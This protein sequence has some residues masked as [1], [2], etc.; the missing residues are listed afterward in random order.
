VIISV[1][2]LKK[3]THI[4][5]SIDELAELI[6]SRLVEIEEVIDLGKKYEGIIVAKVKRVKP[7]DNADKLSVVHIDDGG[8]TP[9]VNRMEDGLVEVV[10]GAPNVREG[11]L[12]AWMPPGITV[13]ST[14]DLAEPLVLA[15]RELRGVI[16]NGMLGSAKELA[17][18]E[19]HTGIVDIDLD[20]QPGTPFA[21]AF[22]LDD[23]LLDIENKSLTHRPD[24]FGIIGFAREAAAIQGKKFTS[25]EWYKS[26]EPKLYDKKEA[27]GIKEPSVSIEDPALCP[28]YEA[29][30]IAGVDSKLPS[31]AVIQSYLRRVGVRPISA[32]V[33]ITNYL[34]L[35]TG[36]P[37]HAFDYDKF[38]AKAGGE[39]R[40]VVRAGRQDEE[41]TLLDGRTVE[42]TSQDI[43]VCAGDTPVALAGAMGGADIEVDDST[44]NILLE[45]ATFNLFNVRGTAMRHAVFSEAATRFTKGQAAQQTAPVIASAIRMLSD[46]A[47]GQRASEIIDEYPGKSEPQTL[48]VPLE[49][50]S[51]T[52]GADLG[53]NDVVSVL[54]NTEFEVDAEAPYTIVATPPFWRSDIHIPQDVIEEVGRIRGFDNIAP[55]LPNRPYRAQ[56]PELFEQ[57]RSRVRSSLVRAGANELLTYSFVHS[58]LLQATGQDVGK[59]FKIVNAL[60]PDL[61]HYRLSL[62]PSL[63]EKV[64][65]NIKL[66]YRDF[67]LFEMNKVHE[68]GKMTRDDNDVPLEFQRLALVFAADSKHAKNYGGAP[69]Y[70]A[71]RLLEYLAAKLNAQFK[72]VPVSELTDQHDGQLMA[73]FEPKRSAAIEVDG[74]II[75]VVGEFRTPVKKALKLPDCT[76]GFELDLSALHAATVDNP[77]PYTP[78]SR[79]PGTEQ[80]VTLK[81]AVD[82][83]FAKVVGTAKKALADSRLEWRIEPIDIYQPQQENQFKNI[84][85][86]IHLT[87]HNKTITT[88]QASN[89]VGQVVQAASNEL[90]AEQ[91]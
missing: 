43:L 25:P 52:L 47:G 11:M 72:Y 14:A 84:T 21:K 18:G 61:Q 70:Q 3:F 29:V 73:P 2:W 9:G 56:F 60:S 5:A 89:V 13:P 87:D 50:V 53:M 23:Y 37:L 62:V 74:R 68:Q 41:L 48:K 59:A 51:D 1:N 33:D 86:R 71:R 80:D 24:C 90:G 16:S 91:V 78:L 69:F 46:I 67:A 42:V 19:D 36:H 32:V 10:C 6:G 34:M 28:R 44:K 76:A 66:G 45:S 26:L 15:S 85:L 8:N 12:A 39:P 17:V 27:E 49:L 75:G 64:H 65:S 20:V 54:E 82:L 63:L 79:F 77:S 38:V 57:F 55:A 7:H 30:V 40:I 31:P 81:V 88:T 4:D 22:E 35:V 83:P 58:R